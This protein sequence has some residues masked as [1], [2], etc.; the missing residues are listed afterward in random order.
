MQKAKS[1]LI[2]AVLI[3]LTNSIY[4]SAQTKSEK[5]INKVCVLLEKGE[6]KYKIFNKT[7]AFSEEIGNGS[8]LESIFFPLITDGQLISDSLSTLIG[9]KIDMNIL[10]T[11]IDSSYETT[12]SDE[13][14]LKS[15]KQW[16]KKSNKY[17]SLKISSP[18]IINTKARTIGFLIIKS[19]SN[20]SELTPLT[21]FMFL[22]ENNEWIEVSRKE[23]LFLD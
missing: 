7:F 3:V 9:E 4:L 19:N 1:A 13:C 8:E 23:L 6:G 16:P 20:H 15:I 5:L 10:D 14:N 17:W 22:W 11:L 2:L 12:I 18:L 21:A